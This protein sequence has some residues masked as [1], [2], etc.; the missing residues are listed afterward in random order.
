[1]HNVANV[2]FD[3]DIGIMSVSQ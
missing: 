3:I 2:P 1:M